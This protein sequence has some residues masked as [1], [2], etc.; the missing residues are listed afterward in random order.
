MKARLPN[1]CGLASV[2]F[3]VM[4]DKADGA[5]VDRRTLDITCQNDAGSTCLRFE[6]MEEKLWFRASSTRCAP[7]SCDPYFCFLVLAGWKALRVE[8]S[9]YNSSLLWSATMLLSCARLL[10]CFCLDGCP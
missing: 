1:P 8:A 9:W 4:Y 2:S 5:H 3:S 7:P 6:Q 10:L